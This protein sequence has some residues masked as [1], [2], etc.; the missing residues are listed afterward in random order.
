MRYRSVENIV[1][2]A[3]EW[4]RA[5][6]GILDEDIQSEA[7]VPRGRADGEGRLLRHEYA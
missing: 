4:R 1:R 6:R 7:A 5:R 2:L 3:T